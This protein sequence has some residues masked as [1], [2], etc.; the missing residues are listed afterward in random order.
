ML[1]VQELSRYLFLAGA[2]PFLLLGTTHAVLTPRQLHERKG[3][4][5]SDPGLAESMARSR[6]LLTRRTDMWRAWIGFNLSH[7]LGAVLFGV[8]VVLVGRTSA[9]FGYNAAL[10]LP[11][12]VVVSIAYLS[13]GITYW[14]H[15][16]I[17]VIGL[18][19]LLFSAAWVL[20]L[21]GPS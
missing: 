15:T 21:V 17:I 6:I 13:L 18:S 2:V 12:A 19:V 1:G 8:L 9:S 11:L 3:L 10:F 20:Y 5:P 4:S 16:P 7:S 14:F